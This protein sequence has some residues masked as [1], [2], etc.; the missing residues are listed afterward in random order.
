[1]CKSNN[2]S[3]IQL[4]VYTPVSLPKNAEILPYAVGLARMARAALLVAQLPGT[5]TNFDPTFVVI[6]H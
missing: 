5:A 6:L 2:N 3:E 1:M 4:L